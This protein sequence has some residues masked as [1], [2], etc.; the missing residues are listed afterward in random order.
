MGSVIALAWPAILAVLLVLALWPRWGLKSLWRRYRELTQK[1]LAEHALKHLHHCEFSGLTARLDSV[2]GVVGIS[3]SR[4]AHLLERLEVLG[5][6]TSSAKGLKLTAEGRAQAL[7]V[8]RIHRL[9]EKYFADHTSLD[10]TLWHDEADRREHTTPDAEVEWLASR[11]GYPRFDPHGAPIPTASGKLPAPRGV[12]L[13]ALQA[14]EQASIVHVEDEP[15]AVYA[16]LVAQGLTVGAVV[17]VLDSSSAQIRLAVAGAERVVTPVIAS[18]VSVERIVGPTLVSEHAPR[19]TQ[20]A[21]GERVRVVGIL[22]TCHG[23]QRHRLLDLGIVPGT[24]VEAELASAN[25]DPMAYRIRGAL[26]ALRSTQAD[27]I[28]VER[29]SEE[30]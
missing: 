3:R 5:L 19:L 25:G 2:A 12:P 23:L 30:S 18:N 4:A 24:E 6:L 22:P 9:W 1:E 20:V 27:H 14:D 29:I 28:Q 16:Q 8:I 26:I 7:R 17:R 15:A 13:S 10:E 11:L 21:K